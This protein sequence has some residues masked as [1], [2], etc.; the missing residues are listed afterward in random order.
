MADKVQI[1]TP[2]PGSSCDWVIVGFIYVQTGC[3]IPS[4]CFRFACAC[5]PATGSA[6]IQL[7]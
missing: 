7:Q 1:V 6:A 2:P 3:E 5:L 4:D